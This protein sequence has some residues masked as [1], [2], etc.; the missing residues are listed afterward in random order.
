M[1]MVHGNRDYLRSLPF[2]EA[3][4]PLLTINICYLVAASLDHV[5]VCIPYLEGCTSV[6]ST[7]RQFPESVIFK[8]GMIASA[9]V[10]MLL[11]LATARF[12]RVCG[13]SLLRVNA[14]RVFAMLATVS[15][16]IYAI[17]LGMNN[18]DYAG[19]RRLGTRG[20]AICSTL[21]M[22]AFAILYYPRRTNE[23]RN[24]FVWLVIT[25]ASLPVIGLIS[26]IAKLLDMPSRSINYIA[27]WNAFVAASIFY[28]VLARLW[29]HHNISAGRPASPSE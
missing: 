27:A 21:A 14:L 5:P 13:E 6:S 28:F 3:L 17:T 19:I 26:E 15:L 2:F 24:L 23:T 29:Q 20:F 1:L 12:L 18:D 16:V 10:L 22:I 8:F 7:G 25:S 9:V 4:L 11:W